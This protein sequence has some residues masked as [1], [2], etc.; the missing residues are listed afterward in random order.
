MAAVV[1]RLRA[2]LH[3]GR[4]AL[5][6][7]WAARQRPDR[8]AL[9]RPVSRTRRIARAAHPAARRRSR[10]APATARSRCRSASCSTKS[11]PQDSACIRCATCD[12]FP[13]LVQAK[14]D[15]H[16]VCV[17]AGLAAPERHPADRRLCR[18][19]RDQ[20]D[21][22]R[23][24]GGGR[25]SRRRGRA[26]SRRHRRRRLRRDQFG[27]AAAA[28][29]QLG[30]SGRARQRLRRGRPSLH[31]PQQLGADRDLAHAE[32]DPLPEDA[33]A[34]RFLFRQRRSRAAARPHPDARQDRCDDVPGRGAPSA[35]RLRGRTSWRATRSISG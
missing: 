8:A 6:R 26:L 15:A 25:A 19:H 14:A 1:P 21:R 13:C 10:R 3:R 27:G 31:V 4:A 17:D 18:A 29:G 12:G 5:S 34:Q 35:A 7:P 33:R 11:K 30:A 16:V 22:Q 23:G 20:R 2:V 24:V 9:R 28:L 32:P